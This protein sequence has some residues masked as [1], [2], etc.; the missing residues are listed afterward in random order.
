[1]RFLVVIVLWSISFFGNGQIV[2]EKGKIID[3]IPISKNNKETFAL[4]LPKSYVSSKLNTV[5]FIFEPAARSKIGIKPFIEASEKNNY[6]LV[7]SNNTRNG[8]YQKNFDI[9]NRLFDYVFSNFNIKEDRI[10]LAGFSGGARLASSIAVLTNKMAGVIACG[11]GFSTTQ[12]HVPTIQKFAYAAICGDLDMNF[13][14]MIRSKEYMDKLNFNHTLFTYNGDHSWPPSKEIIK[15][16]DWLEIQ[17][18]NKGVK[19]KTNIE[20]KQS[21]QTNYALA[22]N[23]ELNKGWFQ[24]LENYERIVST[25]SKFYNLDSI[26]TRIKRIKK[27]KEYKVS[28]KKFS[29]ALVKEDLI[30]EK[31]HTRFLQDFINPDQSDMKWWKRELNVLEKPL[32]PEM[33]KMVKRL[34]YKVF[35]WTITMTNPYIKDATNIEQKRYCDKIKKLVYPGLRSIR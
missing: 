10:F 13:T 1:M 5:V 8:P 28:L 18:H 35:A 27:N 24:A 22:R 20:L 19:I 17:S 34:R 23:A 32:G 25:Y 14:E 3:S 33:D 15:A 12:S 9:T 16:F 30:T 21:Y 2:F 29:K 4:Y 26:K 11:A 7:C 31:L 6:I